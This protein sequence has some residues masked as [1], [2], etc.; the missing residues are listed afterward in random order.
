VNLQA[1]LE[2]VDPLPSF[3]EKSDV[4]PRFDE[5]SDVRSDVLPR[6]DEEPD[7]PTKEERPKPPAPSPFGADTVIDDRPPLEAISALEAKPPKRRSRQL[8]T[9]D[10]SPEE[11]VERPLRR[12]PRAVS[13]Q[14]PQSDMDRA[15]QSA[16]ARSQAEPEERD[17]EPAFSKERTAVDERPLGTLEVPKA[18]RGPPSRAFLVI[19]AFGGLA[20]AAG[21]VYI[22]FEGR[23]RV[24]AMSERD[25]GVRDGGADDGAPSPIDDAAPTP[26]DGSTQPTSTDGGIL[27]RDAGTRHGDAPTRPTMDASMPTIDATAAKGT[28]TLQ[29]GADPW[30]EIYVDGKSAG[31]T[32][33]ELTVTAGHH[34]VEVVFAGETPPRKQTFAVDVANGETKPI[35]ADF[36]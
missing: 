22:F 33:K 36:K 26:D 10:D 30:G 25:A 3:D 17:S 29:V 31:R 34:T 19:A 21:A 35:Q 23:D 24:L 32:P 6:F 14:H 11:R 20:L 5:V 16:R 28:A 7:R 2:Q 15:R 1:I 13:A 8:D 9:V 18:L 27:T 12:T 4:L